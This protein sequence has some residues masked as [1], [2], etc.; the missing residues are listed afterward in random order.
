MHFFTAIARQL[1]FFIISQTLY[2]PSIKKKNIIA[3]RLLLI[4]LKITKRPINLSLIESVPL[5][6]S[7]WS[8]SS[9]ILSTDLVC[10][11]VR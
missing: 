9:G 11:M 10:K 2:R 5:L 1:P 3:L 4:L 6:R 7:A 8:R